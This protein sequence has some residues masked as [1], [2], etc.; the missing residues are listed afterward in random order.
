MSG[1]VRFPSFSFFAPSGDRLLSIAHGTNVQSREHH[2]G[3]S[4]PTWTAA[5][6]TPSA[7]T[8]TTTK[9]CGWERERG[10]GCLLPLG[11]EVSDGCLS[12]LKL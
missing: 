2:S 4:D 5:N 11:G 7:T 8:K 12:S 6:D 9:R 3:R 10:V 1:H